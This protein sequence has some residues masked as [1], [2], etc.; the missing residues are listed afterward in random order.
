MLEINLEN[1]VDKNMIQQIVGLYDENFSPHVRIPHRKL[2]KRMMDEVYKIISLKRGNDW[3]GFSLVSLNE[4]LRT[5]F[6]DYLCVDKK[7]QKGGYGKMMLNELNSKRF[8]PQYEYSILECEY[9]LVPYYIKN[10][11]QKIPL[12]YPLENSK[13]LYMLYRKRCSDFTLSVP[14]M[15]HKFILYGLLFNS[16]IIFLFEA[17]VLL[18]EA[19][20]NCNSFHTILIILNYKTTHT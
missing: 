19:M 4:Q 13:P 17:L 1:R 18:Y 20:L 16:D 2:K 5:I 12:E 14:S 8:F 3:I 11:F 7:F 10:K 6:I 15:Y 9:N